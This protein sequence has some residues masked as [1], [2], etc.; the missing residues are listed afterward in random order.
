M[1][2][3]T[4]LLG[5]TLGVSRKV[6]DSNNFCVANHASIL[7]RIRGEGG[8]QLGGAFPSKNVTIFG[9]IGLCHKW[10]HCIESCSAGCGRPDL[11]I[12]T[13]IQHFH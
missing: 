1:A 12:I 11:Q 10:W 2:Y 7:F 6:L 4:F 8:V 5:G 3:R 9:L 13:A